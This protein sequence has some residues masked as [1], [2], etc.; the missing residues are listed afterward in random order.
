VSSASP[1]TQIDPRGPAQPGPDP[2]QAARI[3]G[4]RSP[5]WNNPRVARNLFLWPALLVVLSLAVFPLVA[6]LVIATSRVSVSG[7]SMEFTFVGL[8]NFNI[9]FFGSQRSHFLGQLMPP[10]LLG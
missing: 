8:Q 6:S 10:T 4:R 2:V 1:A 3:P 9:L 5:D 7:G